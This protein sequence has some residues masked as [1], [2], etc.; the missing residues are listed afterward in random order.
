MKLNDIE[1]SGEIFSDDEAPRL[2]FLHLFA[3]NSSAS[4]NVDFTGVRPRLSLT[5]DHLADLFDLIHCAY[6]M[7]RFLNQWE[8]AAGNSV[9]C[10]LPANLEQTSPLDAA[11]PFGWEG[12]FFSSIARCARHNRFPNFSCYLIAGDLGAYTQSRGSLHPASSS[13]IATPQPGLVGAHQEK[14]QCPD[15]P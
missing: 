13:C 10:E 2:R 12:D 11:A 5:V 6:S 9:V 1:I 15:A 3:R 14:Q 8:I 7:A 4:V